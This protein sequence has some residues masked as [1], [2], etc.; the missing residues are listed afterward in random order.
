[1]DVSNVLALDNH[2]SQELNPSTLLHS[3]VIAVEGMPGAGKTS[4]LFDI[5]EELEGTCVLLSE[6]NLEPNS[7][8]KKLSSKEQSHIFHNLWVER[9]EVLNTFN[10][11]KLCFLLDRTYFSNLAFTYALDCMQS[12]QHYETHKKIFNESF[13]NN[14][15]DLILIFDIPPEIGLQRRILRGD[16]ISWPW[17]NLV[18][19]KAIRQ[20]YKEELPKL[21]QEK[22][23]YINGEKDKN[24]IKEE[25]MHAIQS[26]VDNK[27]NYY[28]FELKNGKDIEALFN[29][30]KQNKLGEA[31]TRVINVFGI[32][33]IYFLK[34]SIQLDRE[35]PVF[36]NNSQLY[37]ISFRYNSFI[38]TQNEGK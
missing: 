29:F 20:F 33:T 9:I 30:A 17:S 12:T 24:A 1:M 36:F 25:T 10:D 35:Q 27:N 14:R 5:A 18:F 28:S 4:V 8:W 15:F 13:G 34:H 6:M 21:A 19:L 11:P 22:I 2:D 23:L 38:K 31:G 16:S 26:V 32:P 7:P 3:K 37:E